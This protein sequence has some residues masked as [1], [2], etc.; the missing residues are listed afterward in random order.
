MRSDRQ[1]F[2]TSVVRGR[3]KLFARLLRLQLE[4]PSKSPMSP[5]SDKFN[6]NETRKVVIPRAFSPLST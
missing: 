6:F 5:Y 3:I 4:S 1:S 2:C